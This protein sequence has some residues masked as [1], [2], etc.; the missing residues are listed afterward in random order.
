MGWQGHQHGNTAAVE[1]CATTIQLPIIRRRRRHCYFAL[2]C[3]VLVP[4]QSAVASELRGINILTNMR[5]SLI[6]L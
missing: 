2:L 3:C 5:S 1:Q 4:L 6:Y